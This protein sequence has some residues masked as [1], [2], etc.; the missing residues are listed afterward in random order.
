MGDKHAEP[1]ADLCIAHAREDVS[2]NITALEAL[3][4]LSVTEQDFLVNTFL[5]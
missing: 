2:Q 4:F 5:N 1:K 3:P